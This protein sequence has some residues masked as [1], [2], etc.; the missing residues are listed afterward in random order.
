MEFGRVIFR[1]INGELPEH[2]DIVT[3]IKPAAP[4]S[5]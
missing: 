2:R 3:G 1:D 4:P 5:S